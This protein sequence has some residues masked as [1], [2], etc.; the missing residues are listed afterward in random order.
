MPVT[1]IPSNTLT[2]FGLLYA[3]PGTTL[4]SWDARLNIAIGACEGLLY[5]HKKNQAAYSQFKTSHIL[6]DTVIYST[7]IDLLAFLR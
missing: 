6:V 2:L 1:K 5:V 4:L 7:T 3:E